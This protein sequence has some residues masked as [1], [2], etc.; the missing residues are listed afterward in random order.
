MAELLAKAVETTRALEQ[1]LGVTGGW[2]E[3][4][5]RTDFSADPA[6]AI[7]ISGALLLRK[8]RIH[9][10]AV[11]RANETSNLH[12]LAVHM[13]PVLECAGQVVFLFQNTIIAPDLLMSR[14][15]AAEVVGDLQVV[16]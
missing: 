14:E 11:L 3:A 4:S 8:A 5:A 16:Y 1:R 6:T 7:R 2:P 10:V 9:T 13:R 12:S 15:R